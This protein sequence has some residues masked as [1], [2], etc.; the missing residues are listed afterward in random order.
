MQAF[1]LNAQIDTALK[2]LE[3]SQDLGE[4]SLPEATGEEQ[5]P[6]IIRL[7]AFCLLFGLAGLGLQMAVQPLLGTYLH[8]ILAK[9]LIVPL[10]WCGAGCISRAIARLLPQTETNATRL[11]CACSTVMATPIT[12]AVVL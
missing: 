4:A 10:G 11:R 3:G 5:A 7:A 8:P 9:A 2:A 1:D 6:F 12:C